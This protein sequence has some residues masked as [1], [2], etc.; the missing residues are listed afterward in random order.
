MEGSGAKGS[1]IHG[2]WLWPR[3]FW[4]LKG[5][6]MVIKTFFVL[7][8][9]LCVSFSYTFHVH[10]AEGLKVGVLVPLSGVAAQA[11]LE[12]KLGIEMAKLEKKTL[13]NKPIELIVEDTQAKP[14]IAVR[15]AEQLV[16]KDGCIAL[17]GIFSSEEGL[18]LTKNIER[19]KV[20]IVTTHAMATDFYRMHK[21]VFRCGQLANDQTAMGNVKAILENPDLNKRKYYVLCH[22]YVWGHDA[23]ERFIPLQRKRA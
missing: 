5:G 13:L 3:S 11:G 16:H 2:I 1:M 23:A 6:G 18:A 12:M 10:P 17:I 8:L 14:R 4:C 7:C 19:L 22:D 21:W 15:K 20:P 9:L